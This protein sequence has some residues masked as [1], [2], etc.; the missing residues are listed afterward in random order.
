MLK[1][2]DQF[3]GKVYDWYENIF[4]LGF[5]QPMLPRCHKANIKA[6][7][8]TLNLHDSYIQYN[9]TVR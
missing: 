9:C 2:S 6:C 1:I 7:F 4:D 5:T 8:A 3:S